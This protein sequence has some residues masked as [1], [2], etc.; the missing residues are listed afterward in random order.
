MNTFKFFLWLIKD[1]LKMGILGGN[2]C[3]GGLYTFYVFS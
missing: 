1:F 2:F 3:I